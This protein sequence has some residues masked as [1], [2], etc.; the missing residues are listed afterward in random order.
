[1]A[2]DMVNRLRRPVEE[3]PEVR[4]TFAEHIEELRQR[5]LKCV[6]FLCA[7]LVASMIFKDALI[8]FIVE[9]HFKAM[10]MLG[11]S[12]AESKLLPGSYGGAPLAFMKLAFIVSLFVSSPWIGYQLWAFVSAGLYRHERKWVVRFAPLSFLLFCGGCV[13]GYVVL[14]P[15]CLVGLAN[16]MG[17]K[18]FTNQYLFADYLN[19]VMLMTIILGGVFQV[20]LIMVFLSKIG[21][22]HPSSYNKWRRAA[23]IANVIFAAVVTPADVITMI[24]VAVP[25]LLLYEVGVVLSYLLA[26]PARKPA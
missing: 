25:L 3:E 15:L 23:I 5:L 9:P 12:E 21:L 13:F 20:P 1:M 6:I 11:L 17:A 14:V 24:L 18:F 8:A 19:L 26:P 10:R 2:T 22:V 16:F 4:M 7:A